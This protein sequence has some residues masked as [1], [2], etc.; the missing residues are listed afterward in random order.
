MKEKKKEIVFYLWKT[1]KKKCFLDCEEQE[2][3]Y[4]SSRKNKW[5]LTMKNKK[6]MFQQ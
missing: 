3:R 1:K 4:D 5:F 2:R 6:A